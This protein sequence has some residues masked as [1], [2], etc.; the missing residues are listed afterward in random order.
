MAV[1]GRP[2]LSRRD[3]LRSGPLSVKGRRSWRAVA[4]SFPR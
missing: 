3:A 2:A 4:R 1:A